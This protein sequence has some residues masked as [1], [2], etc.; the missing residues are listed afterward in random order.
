VY[1]PK[2]EGSPPLREDDPLSPPNLYSATKAAAELRTRH[3]VEREGLDV[4]RVRP[5]NHSGPQR[6]P[7]YVE[8]SFARQ[9]V[10]IER[11]QQEPVLRVGNLGNIRD[12]SDVRD[13]VTHGGTL[14]FSVRWHG[15]RPALLWERSGGPPAMTIRA[16]GI[17]PAWS[18]TERSGE[19][20]LTKL[21]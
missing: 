12:F 16:P 15:E 14:S 10:A 8:S 5:F 17:D 21:D 6:P 20:L 18:T 3:A 4:V 19:A 9:L 2:P 7:D 1:G 11:A 13:V